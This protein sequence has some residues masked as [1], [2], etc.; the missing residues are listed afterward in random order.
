MKFL[1][2]V[3]AT[4]TVV[5]RGVYILPGLPVSDPQM[6]SVRVKDKTQ[7]RTPGGKMIDT[8]IAAIEVAK[9]T[10]GSE[11]PIQ[12]PPEITQDDVPAGH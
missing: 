7:F 4:F 3:D 6:P 2:K 8:Y 11:Y 10:S 12:L 9:T 5:G 1:N